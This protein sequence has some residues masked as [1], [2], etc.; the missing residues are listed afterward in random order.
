MHAG[1]K[2][3][4]GETKRGFSQLVEHYTDRETDWVCCMWSYSFTIIKGDVNCN[5]VIK[6]T[7]DKDK[8]MALFICS[9]SLTPFCCLSRVV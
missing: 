1:Y 2:G 5:G 7:K 4:K 3:T 9:H 6:W 8:S